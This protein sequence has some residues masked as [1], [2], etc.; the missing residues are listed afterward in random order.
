MNMKTSPD[1]VESPRWNDIFA[2]D[3]VVPQG[4]T[5]PN[6]T[7]IPGVTAVDAWGFAGSGPAQTL[8]LTF[9]LLHGY[10]EGTD[11]RIHLHWAGTTA[12]AGNVKWNFGYTIGAFDQEMTA[13]VVTSAVIANP[14]LG[15]NSRPVVKAV[16]F[17]IPGTGRKIGDIIRA[18]VFRDSS[19]VADTYADAVLLFQSGIHYVS[20]ELG[21]RQVFV[22]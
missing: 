22:K 19:D 8:A 17:V 20:D 18:R 14:G 12:G 13:E 7:A 15:A 1:F 16:E 4:A 6:R 9:E 2:T 21:S 5:A 3:V 10:Q 11:L